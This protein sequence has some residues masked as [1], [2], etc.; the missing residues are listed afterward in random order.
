M[1]L[2]RAPVGGRMAPGAFTGKG[3][4]SRARNFP[5]QRMTGEEKNQGRRPFIIDFCQRLS[6]L[7]LKQEEIPEFP[8][9]IKQFLKPRAVRPERR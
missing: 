6:R 2:C 9:N 5:P 7:A 1:S 4:Q 8:E 3:Y